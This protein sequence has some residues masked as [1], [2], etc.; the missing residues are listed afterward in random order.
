LS[1]GFYPDLDPFAHV[2]AHRDP[3]ALGL[4]ETVPG[5]AFQDGTVRLRV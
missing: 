1:V 4:L 2:L 5:E 3:Y